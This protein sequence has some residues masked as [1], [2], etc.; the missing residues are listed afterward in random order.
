MPARPSVSKFKAVVN[1]QWCAGKADSTQCNV[2]PWKMPQCHWIHEWVMR[3]S[4]R[5]FTSHECSSLIMPT[6][7]SSTGGFSGIMYNIEKCHKAKPERQDSEF[8]I[9]WLQD[10]EG[11]WRGARWHLQ[12]SD[13]AATESGF[14]QCTSSGVSFLVWVI[15]VEL[16]SVGFDWWQ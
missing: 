7:T 16:V 8:S 9:R 1:W 15:S 2:S 14:T 10:L 13:S 12:C 4:V 5:T 6:R 3:G 11:N